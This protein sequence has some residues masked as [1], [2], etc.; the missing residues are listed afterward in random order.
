MFGLEGPW[1]PTSALKLLGR[2]V[3]VEIAELNDSEID[4]LRLAAPKLAH[5]LTDG[6]PARDVTRNLYRLGRLADRPVDEPMP[7]TEI[8][9]AI[10]W[11]QTADGKADG[12]HRAR[13]RVLRVLARH[14]LFG[15]QPLD[16]A[17]QPATAVDQ[18]IASE[19]L[20]DFEN[21]RVAF[22]HD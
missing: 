4:E 22:R 18:L 19:S 2:T 9:M 21:D 8:D 15:S 1:L 12:S 11:W 10:Q 5:L 14:A 3:P 7:R 13:S 17:D 16:V 20:R 6:H